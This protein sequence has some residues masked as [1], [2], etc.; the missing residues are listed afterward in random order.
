MKTTKT[1]FKKLIKFLFMGLV[2]IGIQSCETEIPPEDLTP[3]E[4]S[5]QVHGDGFYHVFDQD[6][7]YDDITLRLKSGATYEFIF[8]AGDQGGL[9]SATWGRSDVWKTR[10]TKRMQPPWSDY[11]GHNSIYGSIKW[12]GDSSSPVTGAIVTGFFEVRDEG[13]DT[14]SFSFHVSDFGGEGAMPNYIRKSLSI[15][16]SDSPTRISRR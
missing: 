11:Y 14:T 2:V 4:F 12:E 1:A 9:A 3:P 15:Q 10:I 5:F 6:S 8:S 7:D 16:I 13:Y